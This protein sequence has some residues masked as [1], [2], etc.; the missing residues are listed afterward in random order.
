MSSKNIPATSTTIRTARGGLPRW[1]EGAEERHP[2][3][4]ANIVAMYN[5]ATASTMVPDGAM[6]YHEAHVEATTLFPDDVVRG[7]ALLAALSPRNKWARNVVDAAAMATAFRVGGAAA[8]M[9]VKV[10]TFPAMKAK[11]IVV[12]SLPP[13]STEAAYAA[14]LRGRK[15]TSFMRCIARRT[16]LE[17]CVDGHAVAIAEGHRIPLA[18]TPSLGAA[19]YAAYQAAYVEAGRQLGV[20]PCTAQAVTWVQYRKEHGIV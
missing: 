3:R 8:A 19:K 18:K 6:W 15:V 5:V 13:G 11:A 10:C 2:V 7:A 17:V 1:P 16:P 4:V 14:I 12:L 9:E 20:Q